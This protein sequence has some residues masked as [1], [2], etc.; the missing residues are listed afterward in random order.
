MTYEGLPESLRHEVDLR[1]G[2]RCRWCGAANRY[3][4]K[5]H[6]RY[7]RGVADDVLENLVSLCAACH[8]F[9]H[10]N[11]RPGGARI[12]K[13]VAQQ[14][15]AWVIDHPGTTG[16]SRWRQLRRQ[17]ALAGLCEHGAE[18]DACPYRH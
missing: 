4:Y 2:R 11:P 13:D 12:V 7:R 15:L 16:S 1:D 10:G 9:V 18:L 14:V 3:T 17:W 6:I 5:H 8:S